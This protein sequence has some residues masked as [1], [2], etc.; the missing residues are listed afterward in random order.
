MIENKNF[1]HLQRDDHYADLLH[2][3]IGFFDVIF[4]KYFQF[5]GR[6]CR[7]EFW[8]FTLIIFMI[9]FILFLGVWFIAAFIAGVNGGHED[10]FVALAIFISLCIVLIMLFTV[11][12]PHIALTVRRLHDIGYS[13]WWYLLSLIPYV[14]IIPLIVFFCFDSQPGTNKYGANPK[15]Q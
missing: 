5:S 1:G 12:L 3:G 14:G 8:T 2:L 9:N 13:G 6:D 15:E 4:E 7:K 10:D 11:G